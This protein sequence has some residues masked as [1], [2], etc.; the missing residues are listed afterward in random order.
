LALGT[1]LISSELC[2]TW[3][4]SGVVLGVQKKGGKGK[5]YQ[6]AWSV[7]AASGGSLSRLKHQLQTVDVAQMS[8]PRSGG[9]AGE[10]AASLQVSFPCFLLKAFFD[11]LTVIRASELFTFRDICLDYT[12]R[13]PLQF[14]AEEIW[15]LCL[16]SNHVV[17]AELPV[18]QAVRQLQAER[19]RAAEE[20]E[21]E[22]EKQGK[23]E[24]EEEVCSEVAG[25]SPSSGGQYNMILPVATTPLL[26]TLYSE[27][28]RLYHNGI[29]ITGDV[30]ALTPATAQWAKVFHD[31]LLAP[32]L[33]ARSHTPARQ[34]A[35]MMMDVALQSIVSYSY[36]IDFSVLA[37]S[38]Q[39][40]EALFPSSSQGSSSLVV[41]KRDAMSGLTC[42]L[43]VA[44]L[45][46]YLPKEPI[47]SADQVQ[48][49][50]TLL[51]TIFS[52]LCEAISGHK[53]I[54]YSD[55]SARAD[56]SSIEMP[57]RLLVGEL[58]TL[59]KRRLHLEWCNSTPEEKISVIAANAAPIKECL[60]K[61]VT[62]YLNQLKE[63][64]LPTLA[65]ALQMLTRAMTVKNIG[66]DCLRDIFLKCEAD[67][68]QACSALLATEEAR[69]FTLPVFCNDNTDNDGRLTLQLRELEA[70]DHG[71]MLAF[72]DAIVATKVS[73]KIVYQP[74]AN[75]SYPSFSASENQ[76]LQFEKMNINWDV[77][78]PIANIC[79]IGN[80]NS[81]KS[82]IGGQLL[83]HLN[84]VTDKALE[85]MQH[86]AKQLGLSE[87]LQ[88]AWVMDSLRE[89]R[90]GGFT[91]APKFNGFQTATR[92]FTMIDNP[93]HR[94]SQSH[95]SSL[96][97]T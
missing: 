25:G 26:M 7:D 57:Y 2:L 83:S 4:S 23:E 89:E 46:A 17:G 42:P 62:L 16:S 90:A 47:P 13:K 18:A 92:R 58:Q 79:L 31:I 29:N 50:N 14:C 3:A 87:D 34:R 44:M 8:A 27:R 82:S 84:I 9:E 68:S 77:D 70:D 52:R 94:V 40:V 19:A 32:P 24:E 37:P 39:A 93:G 30:L 22:E 88:F 80:V 64:N 96:V 55:E 95:S 15:D 38:Q 74:V 85:K 49:W 63:Y 33:D 91:V 69:T 59:L 36:A 71:F 61:I 35:M 45:V 11:P 76:S 5:H 53:N 66:I 54:R 75:P 43:G 72:I 67:T 51:V 10:G 56:P 86:M 12:T 48:A 41:M 28:G 6:V 97:L 81:G 21:Q 65:S 20:E 73:P 60:L 78:L 1:S